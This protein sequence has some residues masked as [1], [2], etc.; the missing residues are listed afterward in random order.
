MQKY[1][2]VTKCKAPILLKILNSLI[3]GNFC[4]IV[5]TIYNLS[6]MVR[7]RAYV[8]R[9]FRCIIVSL[10]LCE[11]YLNMAIFKITHLFLITS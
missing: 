8:N 9:Y 3:Y 4:V 10:N 6:K 11:E 1:L 2:T 5:Y 7:F